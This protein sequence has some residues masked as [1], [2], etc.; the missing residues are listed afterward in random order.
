MPANSKLTTRLLAESAKH[1]RTIAKLAER[2]ESDDEE[3]FTQI[4]RHCVAAGVTQVRLADEFKVSPGTISRWQAGKSMPAQLVRAV[5]IQRAVSLL[6][7]RAAALDER[8]ARDVQL[9]AGDRRS[10]RG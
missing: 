10:S 3:A 9:R 6:R 1:F 8:I 2:F 5:I 7:E 4:L